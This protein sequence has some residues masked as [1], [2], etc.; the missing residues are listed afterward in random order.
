MR[1]RKFNATPFGYHEEIELEISTLT[2]RGL[3]LGRVALPGET[4][5]AP[6]PVPEPGAGPDQAPSSGWVVMVPFT[7]PGERVRA[8][9]FRNHKN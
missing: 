9:I 6:A 2:N 7:L 1:N 5:P 4:G 8:R 3:G